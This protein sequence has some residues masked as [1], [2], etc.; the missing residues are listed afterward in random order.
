MTLLY[1]GSGR[2]AAAPLDPLRESYSEA[3]L[4]SGLTAPCRGGIL[5]SNNQRVTNHLFLENSKTKFPAT[6]GYLVY[7][8]FRNIIP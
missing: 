4:V 3:S 1:E 8:K 6:A 7:E 2:Q 5:S